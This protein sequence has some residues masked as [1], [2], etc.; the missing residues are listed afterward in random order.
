M[1]RTRDFILL[2]TA[3]TF[4]I[5]A[6]GATLV[7]Q[8][9]ATG[10][11]AADTALAQQLA[12]AGTA[13]YSAVVTTREGLDRSARVAQMREK[14]ASSG[15]LVAPDPDP[16]G[17]D[18]IEPGVASTTDD[19]LVVANGLEECVGYTPYLGFWDARNLSVVE[20]EGAT[21]VVRSQLLPSGSSTQST[22]VQL[23]KR[24]FSAIDQSCISSDVIGIAND[25]SL[26]RNDELA[27][28]S[29]FSSETR[30]GYAL[31]GFPIFGTGAAAVDQCGGRVQNA[32]Y[33]YELQ[34]DAE[35]IINCFAAAPVMLP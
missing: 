35:F 32:Q 11:Q 17:I 12:G 27:L 16:E 2:F 6:V 7:M 8:G 23:P 4:L 25:G 20:S 30:I 26:I 14:I 33:R 24:Q 21:L 34:T 19:V 29:V 5:S 9:A 15:F 10:S 18:R 3:I 22:F 13:D 28:Y 31:D 1:F